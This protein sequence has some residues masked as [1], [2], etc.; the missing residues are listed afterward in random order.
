MADSW[1]HGEVGEVCGLC[2]GEAG[3]GVMDGYPALAGQH[4]DYLEHALLAYRAGSRSNL[5]MQRVAR[6][7]TPDE[8]S[9]MAAYFA[10]QPGLE[11]VR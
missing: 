3:L 10:A 8:V 6:A 4:Q 7:L 5:I 9:Q 11:P 1:A 2:H